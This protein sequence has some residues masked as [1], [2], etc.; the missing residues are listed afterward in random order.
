MQMKSLHSQIFR[1][2][3]YRVSY[4]SGQ[5]FEFKFT[6]DEQLL[7]RDRKSQRRLQK[8]IVILYIKVSFVV[9]SYNQNFS[10]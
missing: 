5:A 4:Y 6:G 9:F 10:F 3:I 1:P 2:L 7:S 8:Q